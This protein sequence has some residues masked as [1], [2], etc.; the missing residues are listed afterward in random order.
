MG[1]REMDTA[2]HNK[3]VLIYDPKLKTSMVAEMMTAME[4]GERSWVYARYFSGNANHAVAFVVSA[5]TH[6]MPLPDAPEEAP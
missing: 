5:P 1:W 2:P 4:D 6:W 3:R